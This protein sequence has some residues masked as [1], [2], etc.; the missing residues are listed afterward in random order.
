MRI[1]QVIRGDRV[2][3]VS[4]LALLLISLLVVYSASSTLAY[5]DHDGRVIEILFRHFVFI[6]FGVGI[7]YLVHRLPVIYLRNIW[8]ILMPITVLLLII[9]MV[10]GQTI[11]AANASRWI[12]I[13]FVGFTFQPSELAKMVLV[14]YLARDLAQRR[15]QLSDLKKNALH[16]FMPLMAIV[17]LIFP[18]N[19]STA[20]LVLTVGTFMLFI[21]GVPI[22]HLLLFGGTSVVI[23]SL[24]I[25]TVLAFPNLMPN[26]VHTWQSRIENF[27]GGDS[28][29]NY[30]VMKAKT[31]IATGKITGKGPG[32]SVQKHFLPQSSSDFIYAV[33]IE[34]YG[35]IGGGVVWMFYFLLT[36]RFV[37][38]SVSLTDPFVRL[39]VI[40]LGT[41]FSVQAI[42]NM[43]VAV[44]LFPV[45]G[46]TLPLM[47][48]GGSSLWITC[49]ALGIILSASQF[50]QEEVAL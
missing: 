9:A 21:G 3:W 48:A 25:L 16:L 13:P 49:A 27:V 7:L 28:V 19:L 29:E 32:K 2:I 45:T 30:Q 31:A 22:K 36:L 14:L 44:D 12:A 26:R 8:W 24:F 18:S 39:V 1:N 43:N 37:K 23:A 50:K 42:I 10:Q 34:E 47:S 5:R 20:L 40:G 41:F 17:F 6:V 35:L 46:Q 11:G 15:D 33:I 38:L 4:A